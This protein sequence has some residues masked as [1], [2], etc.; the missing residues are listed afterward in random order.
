MG[1]D[2][3][4]FLT[5]NQQKT[6]W[7][8]KSP[9]SFLSMAVNRVLEAGAQAHV[10]LAAGQVVGDGVLGVVDVGDPVITAHVGDVHQVEAVQTEPYFLEVAE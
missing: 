1:S 3:I 5:D 7:A 6:K 10:K 2:W 4:E 8:W 9:F